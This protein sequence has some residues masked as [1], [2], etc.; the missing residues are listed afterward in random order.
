MRDQMREYRRNLKPDF[1]IEA[2]KNIEL[3]I[4]KIIEETKARVILCYYPMKNE[5]GVLPQKLLGNDRVILVPKIKGLGLDLI[6]VS[7]TTTYSKS[8]FGT[9]EPNEGEIWNTDIYVN[10]ALIPAVAVTKD[11]NRLGM[12]KGFFDRT[13][14]ERTIKNI[15]AVVYEDQI[16][17]ALPTD[18]WDKR[19]K[20]IITEKGIYN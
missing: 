10:L 13:L 17:E 9:M 20:G 11:G 1:V 18:P 7:E 4:L 14:Q 5:A 16:V 12:G 3:N 6:Q 2:R 8:S 19:V 15:Y